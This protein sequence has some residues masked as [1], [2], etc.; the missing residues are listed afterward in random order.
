[1]KESA[2]IQGFGESFIF[3]VSTA[4]AR[5]QIGNSISVPVLQAVLKNLLLA[6]ELSP[7]IEIQA[8]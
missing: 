7:S 4:Q 2:K 1:M 3:P 8:A 6:Q 5:K